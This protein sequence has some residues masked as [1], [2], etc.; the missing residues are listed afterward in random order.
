MSETSDDSVFL[1]AQQNKDFENT[2][3]F[4]I[5]LPNNSLRNSASG[6]Q[7]TNRQK[8]VALSSLVE[9]LK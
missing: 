2:Q 4:G 5:T 8:F 1:R 7:I 6:M 3:L 9:G